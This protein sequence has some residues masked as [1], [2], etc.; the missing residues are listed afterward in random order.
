MLKNK[1]NKQTKNEN[2]YEH[3]IKSNKRVIQEKPIF[4]DVKEALL[5]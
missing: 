1:A 2:N 3:G 5:F 4:N